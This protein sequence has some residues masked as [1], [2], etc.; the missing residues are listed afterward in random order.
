MSVNRHVLGSAS[1]LY[2]FIQMAV[3]A[4]LTALAGFGRDPALAAG[5]VLVLAGIV[6]QASFWIA[7]RHEAGAPP[8]E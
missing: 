7:I 5:V 8:A 1:G 6:A 2:G 4:A 3:G